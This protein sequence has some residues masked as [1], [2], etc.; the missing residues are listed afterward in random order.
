[1]TVL[2]LYTVREFYHCIIYYADTVAIPSN[3][4]E[5]TVTKV[6]YQSVSLSW[7]PPTDTGGYSDVNYIITVI[8]L[9]GDSSWNI[10]TDDGTTNYTVNEL[11]FNQSYIFNV[12]ANN[13]IGEG[14]PSN[15]V[16][17]IT[18]EGALVILS[19]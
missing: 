16:T 10:T 9:N 1:M 18:G 4:T 14:E 12:R 13:S 17:A 8:P 6:T 5:L 15:N 19:T 7:S 3:V 2:C 11:I